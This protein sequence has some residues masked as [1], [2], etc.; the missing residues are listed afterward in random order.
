VTAVSLVVSVGTDHHRF[1]RLVEWTENWVSSVPFYVDLFVQYGSSRAPRIGDG[2]PLLPRA[3]MLERYRRADIVVMQGG[4]GGIFDVAS[5]GKLPIVVPRHPDFG[6]HVDAHQ[7]V[8]GRFMADRSE[9]VL[10]EDEPTF[11]DVLNRAAANPA[12]LLRPPR[13]S[14]VAETAKALAA[15]V[16]EVMERP[17]GFIR[18]PRFR[19][20]GGLRPDAAR[21]A[22][23][24]A[25]R[26][27]PAWADGYGEPVLV[28]VPVGATSR[29]RSR[30]RI[31]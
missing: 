7:V 28:P 14:P 2:A 24:P 13:L 20:V 26:E 19:Q 8:F 21:V 18:W 27:A 30:S 1:D 3:E 23:Q 17:A 22:H 6:E 10:V 29:P 11:D 9:A 16:D 4:P 15:V 31:A 12:S 25:L 5:V